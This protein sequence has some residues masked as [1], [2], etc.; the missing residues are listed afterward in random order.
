MA[1][2]NLSLIF[3]A[4]ADPTRREIL[5]MLMPGEKTVTELVG[6]F[7]ISQPAISKHLKV[8]EQAGLVERVREAQRRP[9]K[10]RVEPL[11]EVFKW[12]EQYRQFWEQ[13]SKLLQEQMTST[14]GKPEE[15]QLEP[16]EVQNVQ[17]GKAQSDWQMF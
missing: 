8:L 10:L 11:K 7:E 3:S 2:D 4:L 14:P 9:A 16:G 12:L 17:K 5:A 13:G 15:H 1:K 6:E